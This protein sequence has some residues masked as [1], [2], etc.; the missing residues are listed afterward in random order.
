MPP[1]GHARRDLG[2]SL[3]D[4]VFF[5]L[6]VGLGET[7]L[8]AF[9][10]ALGHGDVTSGLLASLPML[11]GGLVQLA[12]PR[13]AHALGSNRRWVVA[14]ATLQAAVFVP[15]TWAAWSG[16]MGALWLY[17]AAAAY[18]A[19]GLGAGPAWTSWFPPQVPRRLRS[20]YFASRTRA[21]Q[22]A[23]FVG[24]VG[25]G[26]A[27]RAFDGRGR[28][29]AGFA[30]LFALAGIF[31]AVSTGLLAAHSEGPARP[32]P[33]LTIRRALS[34]MGSSELRRLFGYLVVVQAGVNF[35]APYF[36]P[37]MLGRLGLGYGAYVALVAA[38]FGARVLALPLWGRLGHRIG[39]QRLLWIG[40]VGIAP[41][42]L[43]WAA[44]DD[45]AILFA[46]QIGAGVVWAAFELGTF[47]AL[48]ER[49]PDGERTSLLA[50][51]NLVNAAA[52]AAGSI[53]GGL[54]LWNFGRTNETYTFLF[55]G[56]VVL[57]LAALAILPRT[58]AP[59][60]VPSAEPI[61][62]RT[63]AVRPTLGSIERPILADEVEDR[64]R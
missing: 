46:A 35:A 63:I 5:S 40:A 37:Y 29:L 38:A 15:L 31:R 49:L 2:L 16:R 7:Y 4:G 3:W 42:A 59:A 34:R 23:V 26:I 24:L 9:A 54:V 43:P 12:A 33:P 13:A 32:L 36:T 56:T 61:G 8:P 41:T 21:A 62:A 18:W 1:Q 47:L 55:A 27:L 53:A 28:A 22:A 52:I 25:G 50:L 51:Y 48:F 57:R 58:P 45:F 20:S 11:A 60:P 10:L 14:A 30:L 6:M 17:V 44:T 64:I 39:G 19:A